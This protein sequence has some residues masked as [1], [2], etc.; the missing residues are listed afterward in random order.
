MVFEPDI[1]P[2][3]TKSLE[4]YDTDVNIKKGAFPVIAIDVHNPTVRD[5]VLAGQTQIGI[6]QPVLTVLPAPVQERVPTPATVNHVHTQGSDS[7]STNNEVWDPPF[8]LSHL[9]GNQRQVL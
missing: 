1:D 2:Q 9:N 3:R 4:F 6:V 8:D 5:I 7:A